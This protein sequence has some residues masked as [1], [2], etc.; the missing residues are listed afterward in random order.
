MTVS[1]VTDARKNLV[2][3]ITPLSIIEIPIQESLSYV[4]AEDIATPRPIPHF[5]K[6]PYDGY[7]FICPPEGMEE[8]TL[9]VVGHIGAGEV[10][11][12]ELSEG[13]AVRIMT[14][15]PVPKGANA[16]AKIE[17]SEPFDESGTPLP[18]ME[19]PKG[20][21]VTV[22]I[23]A[24][25]EPG[26]NVIVIGEECDANTILLERGQRITAGTI[27]LLA[28]LGQKNVSVY[29]KPKVAILTSGQELQSQDEPLTDH[30][31]YNSNG[32]MLCALL[33]ANGF[34]AA[35][36]YH[37]SD[38]ASL[39]DSEIEKLSS[40]LRDI[41]IVIST[42]GVSVG[43]YD[44]MPYIYESLG[45]KE[46]YS[47]VL[48]RPGSAQYAGVSEKTTFIGLSGNPS[49]AFNAFWLFALP[50]LRKISGEIA[51][52]PIF[53]NC[54]VARKIKKKN[55]VDRYIQGRVVTEDGI[56]KFYPAEVFTSNA[57]CGLSVAN[58]LCLMEKG[59]N[60]AEE[61]SLVSVYLLHR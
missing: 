59:T 39:I 10:Y 1:T 33:E 29:R 19:D 11:S 12:A 9:K 45:A 61:G 25:L 31:V 47:K 16:V 37:V 17:N 44:F 46:I 49:G 40:M 54:E 23:K 56:T 28:S 42:G 15:A 26:D 7:A 2:D 38:D 57:I 53:F 52:E 5:N 20:K 22:H 41:D 4:L 58:A 30:T 60:L 24:Q 18:R 43:D 14:G 27:A 32:P 48:M 51:I 3:A 55:P 35:L 8:I 13:E 21:D 36:V 50:A 6:S 34:E